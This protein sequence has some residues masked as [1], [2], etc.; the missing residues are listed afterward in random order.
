MHAVPS[1]PP[2]AAPAALFALAAL[3]AQAGTTC[4]FPTRC[5]DDAP[6]TASDLSFAFEAEDWTA[7]LDLPDG[8]VEGQL[9]LT[10]S[11]ATLAIAIAGDGVHLLT[12]MDADGTARYTRHVTPADGPGHAVTW[13]GHCR[14]D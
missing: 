10:P 6:C 13:L 5:T 7:R 9:G 1:A 3:P 11:G 12:V 2:L 8:P 14:E 4:V